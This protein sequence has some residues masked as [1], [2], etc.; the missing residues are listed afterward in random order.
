M[1]TTGPCGR[2]FRV[3]GVDLKDAKTAV[4]ILGYM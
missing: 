4:G 2:S 1:L 3:V